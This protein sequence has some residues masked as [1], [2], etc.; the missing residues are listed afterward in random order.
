MIYSWIFSMD[1]SPTAIPEQKA[2]TME[3][4][5]YHT[6]YLT[7]GRSLPRMLFSSGGENESYVPHGIFILPLR[8][9]DPNSTLWWSDHARECLNPSTRRQ[10]GWNHRFYRRRWGQHHHRYSLFGRKLRWK[11]WRQV[12]PLLFRVYWK[13]CQP[14]EL[15]LCKWLNK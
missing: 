11:E 4:T 14:L 2:P 13:V 8:H 5:K 12:R 7:P 10:G 1:I 6:L 3:Q 15:L 9:V